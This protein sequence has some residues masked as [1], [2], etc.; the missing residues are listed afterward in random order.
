MTRHCVPVVRTE[1]LALYQGVVLVYLG[2]NTQRLHEVL[3][4]Y[5]VIELFSFQNWVK[6]RRSFFG[7]EYD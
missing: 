1:V 4:P 7:D 2:I 6:A 5:I 3:N